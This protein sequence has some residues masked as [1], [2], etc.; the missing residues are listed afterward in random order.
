[1]SNY[2]DG[3]NEKLLAAIPSQAH[4]VLE[5]GCANGRLG[6][7][8]KESNPNTE[9]WG[10][11]ISSAA[12]QSA[13]RHL[14]RVFC[15]DIEQVDLKS[16]GQGFDVIVIG[17][18]LEHL[19]EP[20][21]VLETL[22]DMVSDG[23]RLVCCIPNMAHLSVVQRLVAGDI[24][25][26]DVGLLDRT[27]TRFF[28]QPS[29]FKT[30]LDGGWM[31]HLQDSYRVEAAPTGFAA[32]IIQAA[33][34]LGVPRSTAIRN[35]GLYQMI[36]VC[37][38]SPVDQLL[39]PGRRVPFS[40]IVPVNKPW[41]HELNV[42]RSPGLKEVDA[43]VIC[44]AGAESAAAAYAAGGA[45]ATCEW[46]ILAHQD[47]YFPRGSGLQI[48]Q[49][50]GALDERGLREAPVGF[51]GLQPARHAKTGQELEYAGLVIDRTSLFD[52]DASDGAISMDEFAVAIHR[53]C[54]I[55]IDGDLGW[56]LWGTDL[57]LQALALGKRESVAKI[58]QVP[59]FHNSLNDY[60]LPEAFRQSADRL[61]AKYPQWSRISTLCGELTRPS[62]AGSP[63]PMRL[64]G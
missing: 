49:Q 59:L 30:L 9:W 24:S 32:H 57:C 41:Q 64:A 19:R 4:R 38:K 27:H 5:L 44:I 31:P 45:R 11:E 26:D 61:L 8:Y 51:A 56:H 37:R 60:V 1:M 16:L 50:L 42:A 62:H 23:G 47:V 46:R 21:R 20:E 3:L 54:A 39:K 40:V 14:D 17:D 12:A 29:A 36:L 48:A 35:L 52:H 58:L 63:Q 2:Y 28:S 7:R 22:N 55:S 6:R 34:A 13:A 15:V 25:Y 43:E 18:L 33:E 53:D 10:V